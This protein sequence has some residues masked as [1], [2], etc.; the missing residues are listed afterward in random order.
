MSAILRGYDLQQTPVPQT[1]AISGGLLAAI[2][3]RWTAIR[4]RQVLDSLPPHQRRDVLG[5]PAPSTIGPRIDADPHAVRM[6]MHVG[7]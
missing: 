5:D 2:G 1:L 6:L 4:T 3:R 7:R